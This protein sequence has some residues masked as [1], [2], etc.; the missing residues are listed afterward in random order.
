[1]SIEFTVQLTTSASR[2]DF[3]ANCRRAEAAGYSG[4]SVSD[5]FTAQLAPIPAMAAAAMVTDRLRLGF[6]V[7]AN[8][9]RHPALLAKEVATIDVLSGGRTVL[10]IG[11]G[12]MTH[13]YDS[14]GL[15]LDS[16]GVR[17][18]R[19]VESIA[20][21]RGLLG[22][23]PFTFQGDHY[24][25]NGL[26]GFPKPVQPTVPLLIGG[27]AARMLRTAGRLADIVGIALDNRAGVMGQES[28]RSATAG[29]FEQ[30]LG[31]VNQGA[32]ARTSA[33][34]LSVRVLLCA[35][36]GDA[37]GWLAGQRAT[38]GLAVDE[39]LASPHVLVGTED[40][41]VA[42]LRGRER[43]HGLRDYVVSQSA[44]DLMAPIIERLR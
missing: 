10:G 37:A 30:K 43:S 3:V 8:D 14:T 7:L 44:L 34:R 33:P 12:W 36:T 2:A 23:H 17:I 38:T 6:N 9:F 27:G 4:V 24:R 22:A 11:A 19:L 21:L 29:A 31:W 40:E 13:D 16:P 5:H 32:A 28:W 42:T 39:L 20:V 35:V 18:D 41:I 26:D 15:A 1:M 25:I